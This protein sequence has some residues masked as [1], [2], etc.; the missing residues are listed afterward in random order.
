MGGNVVCDVLLLVKV[1]D[2]VE[3]RL[4]LTVDSRWT[5]DQDVREAADELEGS[6]VRRW[7]CGRPQWQCFAFRTR[8]SEVRRKVQRSDCEEKDVKKPGGV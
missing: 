2:Q 4:M 1:L 5:L 8:E 7:L 6:R 3:E